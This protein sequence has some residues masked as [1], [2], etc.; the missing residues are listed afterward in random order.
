MGCMGTRSINTELIN[1]GIQTEESD[2]RAHVCVLS[3]QVHLFKT[4]NGV[5]ATKKN[6][7]LVPVYT[8]GILTAKGYLVPPED[9]NTEIVWLPQDWL[10]EL[11]ITET[12]NTTVKGQKAIEIV[13]RLILQGMCPLELSPKEITEKD[14]Q[15]KGIDIVVTLNAKIEVKCDYRGGLKENGGTGNLFLQIAECNP[16]KRY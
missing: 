9:L 5:K 3:K 7:R 11:Q 6:Y 14:I 8:N 1:Y 13:K 2:F 4:E 16:S 10:D 12:D 15:I